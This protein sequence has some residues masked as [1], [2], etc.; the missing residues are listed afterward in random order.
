MSEPTREQ[1]RADL[2]RKMG[3][4]WFTD[5]NPEHDGTMW[6]STA[7][8]MAKTIQQYPTVHETEEILPIDWKCLDIPNPYESAADKDKLVAWLA[9]QERHVQQRF[10]FAVRDETTDVDLCYELRIMTA[11]REII[12]DAAWMAIQEKKQCTN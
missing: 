3:W 12:A 1:K 8:L 5:D 4:K 10:I 9:K 11:P 2:A 6:L 7:S